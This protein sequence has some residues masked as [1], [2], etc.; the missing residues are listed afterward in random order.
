VKNVQPFDSAGAPT[1][2][3]NPI[4]LPLFLQL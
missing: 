2:A 4:F 1:T 3:D